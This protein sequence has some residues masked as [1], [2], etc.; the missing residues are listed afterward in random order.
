MK[1]PAIYLFVGLFVGLNFSCSTPGLVQVKPENEH[2][3]YGGRT[4]VLPDGS[5]VLIGAASSFSFATEGDSCFVALQNGPHGAVYNFVSLEVDGEY[6]GRLKIEGDSL[7]WYPL[8]LSK[9][10]DKHVVTVYKATEASVGD[11]R[12]A[13]IR[14]SGLAD[15]PA[16]P[17]LKIEFIGNSITCGMGIDWKEIPCD[18][19]EWFDQHN[20]YWAYGPRVARAMEAQFMLSSVSG[21]GMYRTW[22]KEEP[23]MPAVYAN[24]YLN[25]DSL[26]RWNFDRFT[27]NVVSICLGTNDFSDGDGGYG[28]PAFSADTFCADYIGFVKT[29]YARNPE[30][31]VVLLTSPIFDE[32]KNALLVDCL[33]R[34]KAY[35]NAEKRE[36]PIQ[37]FQFHDIVGHGCGGHP[38]REDQA[39]MARQLLPFF[40]TLAKETD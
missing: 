8:V 38:D 33:N 19:G 4:D 27:P 40:R 22:N 1:N 26:Q 11:I 9:S 28:R 34:V 37:V 35:F 14:V 25:T 39:E 23:S 29:I 12:F 7:N 24:R 3:R 31:Q 32:T 21:I 36:K 6:Q 13:G 5:V 10:A 17:D 2:L 30:V 20:A 16:L 18:T 15:L